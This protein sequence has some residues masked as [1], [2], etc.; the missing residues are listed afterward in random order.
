MKSGILSYM[1][2]V[3]F[4]FVSPVIGFSL[5]F[6]IK[7]LRRT[8]F[9]ILHYL[10]D[11]AVFGILFGIYFKNIG[12]L[13]PFPVMIVAMATIF[14]FEIIFWN[15]IYRGS[16]S[17]FDFTDWVVPAFLIASTIYLVG[18]WLIG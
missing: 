11:I 2:V 17:Y 14:A 1:I 5:V 4:S 7:D 8:S 6:L 18:V 16:Q 15:F 10:I 12:I 9:I 3:L 13:K